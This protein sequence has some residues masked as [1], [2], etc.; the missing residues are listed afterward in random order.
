MYIMY[1]YLLPTLIWNL[2]S[3]MPE[4]LTLVWRM[5]WVVGM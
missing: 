3:T 5:S 2:T 1:V 4:V